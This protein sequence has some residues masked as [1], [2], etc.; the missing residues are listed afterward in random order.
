MDRQRP[1]IPCSF[2]HGICSLFEIT[3][4]TSSL[5]LIFIL[6]YFSKS[7]IGSS[8]VPIFSSRFHA[9][10][11]LVM[12]VLPLARWFDGL[13]CMV[14]HWPVGLMGFHAW[15]SICRLVWWAI[16]SPL[17]SFICWHCHCP[18]FAIDPLIQFFKKFHYKIIGVVHLNLWQIKLEEF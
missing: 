13:S 17:V 3:N 16:I 7:A 14:F 9:R 15:S 10:Y 18:S 5:I 2:F 4:I 1:T 6:F 12:H 11:S 8:S